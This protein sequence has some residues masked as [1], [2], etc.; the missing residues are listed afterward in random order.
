MVVFFNLPD[1][2][3]ESM[4]V[5]YRWI[6][7]T[8]TYL[9]GPY[10]FSKGSKSPDTPYSVKTVGEEWATWLEYSRSLGVKVYRRNQK[11]TKNK[12]PED[13]VDWIY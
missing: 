2:W 4:P 5:S 3:N 1:D 6:R 9:F 11:I 13:L 7:H 8:A 12:L 10:T